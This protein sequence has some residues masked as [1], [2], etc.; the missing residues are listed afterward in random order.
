MKDKVAFSKVNQAKTN[1]LKGGCMYTAWKYLLAKYSGVQNNQRSQE[2][3]R[4]MEQ[5]QPRTS[6]EVERGNKERITSHD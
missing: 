4:H 1:V 5:L 2:F 3:S 6:T